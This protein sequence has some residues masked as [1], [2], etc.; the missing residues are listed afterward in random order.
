MARDTVIDKKIELI[1][2]R[3]SIKKKIKLLKGEQYATSQVYKRRFEPIVAP[4]ESLVKTIKTELPL[5]QEVK[6]EKDLFSESE[7]QEEETVK[8]QQPTFL[9]TETVGEYTPSTSVL[10]LDA[11][12]EIYN[13]DSKTRKSFDKAIQNF[14]NDIQYYLREMLA[15]KTG[16]YDHNYGIRF[17]ENNW[18]IGDSTVEINGDDFII[19][20]VHYRGTPGL[21]ELLFLKMP[22]TSVITDNDLSKYKAIL[23][24]TNAHKRKYIARE[25]INANRGYKYIN[26]ISKFFPTEHKALYAE[27]V[28][29]LT[30]KSIKP[31]KTLR[32]RI[33]STTGAGMQWKKLINNRVQLI[34]WNTPDELVDRLRELTAEKQAGNNSEFISNEILNIIQELREEKII[35]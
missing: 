12:R 10:T 23:L 7:D 13:T 17:E 2:A 15:D 1:K 27:G 33:Q 20:N 6:S 4:I 9:E 28:Q 11:V 34:Y 32:R 19:S 26:I 25:R 31:K 14:G 35:Y 22:D 21:Y 8:P 30:P 16:V 24:S 5:K 29:S 18:M 3:K